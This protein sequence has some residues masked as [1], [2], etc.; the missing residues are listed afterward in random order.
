MDVIMDKQCDGDGGKRSNNGRM[1]GTKQDIGGASSI[2]SILSLFMNYL[3]LRVWQ[4]STSDDDDNDGT[5]L[6][7]K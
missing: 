3:S 4:N 7:K 5:L 6:P 2:Q 1:N